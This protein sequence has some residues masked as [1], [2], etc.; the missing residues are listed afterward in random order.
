MKT[1]VIYAR[2]STEIQNEQSQ[3][4]DLK[5]FATNNSIKVVKIFQEKASGFDLN[6][7][8]NSYDEMKE[9]ILSH[10]IKYV[11][12]WELSRF[13]RNSLHTL[14]EIDYY[15]Q[16]GVSIYFKK[17]NIDT[18]SNDPTSN[19]LLTLLSSIAQMERNTIV[20]RSIRGRTSSAEKGKRVG[21]AVMPY[22]FLADE[23]G[24]IKINETEAVNVRLMYDLASQGVSI[25]SIAAKLNSLNI[26]TRNTL[27]GR[28]RTLRN[29]DEITIL[30]RS[31][32]LRKILTSTL[33][34]GERTYKQTTIIPIDKIVN[35]EIWNKV[36][37]IFK[38]HIGY[39][40]TTKHQYLFKSKI[41]CG[42]CG[43]MYAT[44]TDL[45]KGENASYYYCRGR[46]DKGIQCKN[47]QIKS[48]FFDEKVYDILFTHSKVMLQIYKDKSKSFNIKEKQA[49]I[50]YFENEI[51]GQVKRQKRVIELYKDGFMTKPDF[52]KEQ[53]SIRKNTITFQDNIASINKEIELFNDVNL[54]NTL[55]SLL[56]ETNYEIKR[57]FILKYVDKIKVFKVNKTNI[58]FSKLSHTD[59]KGM[60]KTNLKPLRGNDKV[61]FIEVY[62]F[63]DKTPTNIVLTSYSDGCYTSKKL[64]YIEGYLSMN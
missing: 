53:N 18:L 28:M 2:V 24:Y 10:H 6:A 9:Y 44:R 37:D 1:A 7:E 54:S 36:Q 26:P 39:V 51:E 58:D 5:K 16:Q 3:I 21:F 15:K 63:G 60:K 49:Q 64:T 14:N 20:S 31:N 48:N 59:L 12:C 50:T 38:G 33:Y 11:L 4:D 45:L 43:L 57:E 30:W 52:T 46:K 47:G 34:K 41:F 35:E 13:G 23:N 17:E 55:T 40:N 22:G 32:T 56:W 42:K 27:R 8:R 61:M 19:L 62:A 25:K 29:G